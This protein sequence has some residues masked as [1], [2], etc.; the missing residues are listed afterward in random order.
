MNIE[1]S[2]EEKLREYRD[3]KARTALGK[4]DTNKPKSLVAAKKP[5]VKNLP[6]KILPVKKSSQ[7]VFKKLT[8]DKSK[9]FP[10]TSKNPVLKD[11]NKVNTE[12]Q[13][14]A[15]ISNQQ[16]SVNL[17]VNSDHMQSI[18]FETAEMNNN[19][20]RRDLLSETIQLNIE[21][22]S[23]NDEIHNL[24]MMNE[25]L[26]EELGVFHKRLLEAESQLERQATII[27][28]YSKKEQEIYAE[29]TK[30]KQLLSDKEFLIVQLS[31]TIKDLREQASRYNLKPVLDPGMWINQVNL[32]KLQSDFDNLK[33]EHMKANSILEEKT[34]KIM[35]LSSEKESTCQELVEAK[36][37]IQLLEGQ[38]NQSMNETLVLHQESKTQKQLNQSQYDSLYQTI[39]ERDARIV[40]LKE[41]MNDLRESQI[42]FSKVYQERISGLEENRDV[43]LKK[44]TVLECELKDSEEC[45]GLFEE[46][47][48]EA[49]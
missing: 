27:T 45:I 43:L 4:A 25:K 35:E 34:I 30:E 42:E 33:N 40:S 2:R 14:K 13:D 32:E 38:L 5:P 7:D 29:L 23:R 12:E 24:R 36:Q 16:E 37:S 11:A 28:G 8:V 19:E 41:E 49:E 6:V 21:L 31:D 20:E 17:V 39:A 48:V 3:R 10:V 46:Q 44:I 1:K 15:T 9:G 22:D 47:E 26:Q 18:G